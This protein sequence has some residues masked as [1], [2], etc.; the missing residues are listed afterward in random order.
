MVKGPLQTAASPSAGISVSVDPNAGLKAGGNINLNASGSAS[1]AL[2][3]SGAL[4]IPILLNEP[5][6]KEGLL[7]KKGSSRHNWTERWFRLTQNTLSYSKSFKSP[8][9]KGILIL[10]EAAVATT[11]RKPWAFFVATPFKV[12]NIWANS[13]DDRDDWMLA[14]RN[15]IQVPMAGG[16]RDGEDPENLEWKKKK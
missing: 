6:L 4:S 5:V 10:K 3:A 2:K 9:P 7:K 13:K 8:K 12:L 11:D 14:I 1:P 16:F 15:A